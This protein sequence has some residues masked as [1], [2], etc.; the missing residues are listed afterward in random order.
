MT[1]QSQLRIANALMVVGIVP[2]LLGIA[3]IFSVI[4]YAKEHKGQMG[5]SD[6]FLMI[7]VL[8]VT[9]VLALL[10]S[11][12]SALWSAHLERRNTGTQ[13][14]AS[15][16]VRRSVYVI[17]IAPFLWYLWITFSLL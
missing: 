1:L 17:L 14:P 13:A 7:G 3:W 10:V 15:K 8:F 11:G 12:S 6:A 9:Y 4:A 5:G 16:V 2:L